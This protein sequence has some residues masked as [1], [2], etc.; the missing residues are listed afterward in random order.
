LTCK[1]ITIYQTNAGISF[2]FTY[3]L[4]SAHDSFNNVSW[5]YNPCQAKVN[6]FHLFLNPVFQNN[7]L[8]L[9]T[10][11]NLMSS[12]LFIGILLKKSSG[13]PCMHHATRG[14][15]LAPRMGQRGTITMKDDLHHVL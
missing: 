11:L 10:A 2:I 6:E 15:S 7:V 3:K 1:P 12:L 8:W 5:Y 4:W 13:W 14:L 9:K